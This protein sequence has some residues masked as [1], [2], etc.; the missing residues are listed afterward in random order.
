[1]N[2]ELFN[3][4]LEES[5]SEKDEELSGICYIYHALYHC[6]ELSDIDF[7]QFSFGDLDDALSLLTSEIT[8]EDED[9]EIL[10]SPRHPICVIESAFQSIAHI[11]STPR[12]RVRSPYRFI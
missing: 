9:G 12:R 2:F 4:K 8:N 5:K 6:E 1:M 10:L 3:T 7:N 11:N